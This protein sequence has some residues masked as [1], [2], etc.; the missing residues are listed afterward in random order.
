MKISYEEHGQ[1][2]VLTM[3]GNFTS[4]QVDQ[5]VRTTEDRLAAGCRHFVLDM[6]HVAIVDSAGLEAMLDLGDRLT[7]C[8]GRMMLVNLDE[9]VRRILEVTRLEREFDL[10]E[11]V[12][13]AARSL[14]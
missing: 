3:S 7:S 4:D 5:F 6:G 11:S 8:G 1:V 2:C 9:V 13:S 14:R 12:E 10:H